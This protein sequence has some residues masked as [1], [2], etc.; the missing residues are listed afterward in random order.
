MA[1]EFTDITSQS[2]GSRLLDSIKGI[3]FGI[4]LIPISI[5][6]LFWNENRAVTTAKGLK[7]GAAAVVSIQPSPVVP[8]NEQKLVHLSGEATTAEVLHD[9]MFAVGAAGIRLTRK[10][11]IYQWKE[12]QSS[13]TRKKLGGG[14]ETA[15]TYKYQKIWSD[16]L[17]D[18]AGF[19]HREGH[20]NPAA[21]IAPPLTMLASN[22]TMGAFQLPAGVLQKM[23]GDEPLAATQEDLAKTAADLQ[24]RMKLDAGAFYVGKDSNT[25]AIGDQRVTF[26]ILK[27][28]VWSIIARQ[29]GATLEP[30][31]THAGATIERVETGTV[32]A[33]LMFQHAANENTL[34]TWALRVLGY[35]LM[36]LGLGLIIKPF[37]VFA[38]VIPLLGSIIGIGTTL[39]AMLLAFV[40]S[41]VVIAIAWF[42]VRPILAISLVVVAA[43]ALVMAW[44]H[45]RKGAVPAS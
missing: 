34:L 27:P 12:E 6:L 25:L 28:A 37:S 20:E 14:T 29:T 23:Q 38:D 30:Y 35:V 19:K 10:V 7:E 8:A 18:S 21:M 32:S 2:W 33:D 43:A 40:G 42:V 13:E 9:P 45:G 11:E 17:I 22:V 24:A 31:P 39:A 15:T 16:A 5:I 36:A 44:R 3:L 4:I 1:D 41:V 26:K